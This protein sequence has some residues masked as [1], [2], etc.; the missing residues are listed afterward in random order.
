MAQTVILAPLQVASAVGETVANFVIIGNRGL[1]SAIFRRFS[2]HGRRLLEKY[3]YF[4]GDS[5]L[6]E[7]SNPG[8][9]I[10]D[11]I[12]TL[13]WAL[14][15]WNQTWVRQNLLLASMS[16]DEFSREEIAHE[17]LTKITLGAGAGRWCSFHPLIRL[18]VFGLVTALIIMVSGKKGLML[19]VALS[20]LALLQVA[21]WEHRGHLSSGHGSIFFVQ[22]AWMFRFFSAVLGVILWWAFYRLSRQT[23]LATALKAFLGASV[24]QAPLYVVFKFILPGE[25]FLIPVAVLGVA[26]S[27]LGT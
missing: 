2:P 13:V 17:R 5:V 3:R 15:R 18:F 19:T 10:G 6:Q 25:V 20:S 7:F 1:A 9:N 4:T 8:H 11:R 16:D 26:L 23:D 22:N 14:L 12:N 21:L 24:L 27:I